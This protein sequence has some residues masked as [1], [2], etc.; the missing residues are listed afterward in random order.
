[1]NGSQI[2]GTETIKSNDLRTR[3]ER[4]FFKNYFT[5]NEINAAK[6]SPKPA[7]YLRKLAVETSRGGSGGDGIA[8]YSTRSGGKVEFFINPDSLTGEPTA[9]YDLKEL[10]KRLAATLNPTAT[11]EP[12]KLPAPNVLKKAAEAEEIFSDDKIFNLNLSNIVP[13]P[14]EP[15]SRRRSK[16]KPEDIED[17]ANSIVLQGLFSPIVV[18]PSRIFIEKQAARNYE[19]VF[20]ERRYLAHKIKNLDKIKCFVRELSDAQ[21]LEMQYQENHQRSDNDPL[22]DAFLFQYL[23]THEKYSDDDLADHFAKTKKEITEKLKLNDLIPEACAELSAGTLPLR[24]AYHL[25]KFPES[26]QREI[27]KSQLAYKYNDRSERAV[28]YHEFKAEV[29]ENIVRRLTDAPFSTIDPRLHIKQLICPKCPDR[30]GFETYLFPD[31]AKE[32]SCLNAACFRLKTNTH[33][34]LKREELAAKIPNPAM[35]SIE[36]QIKHVPLVTGKSYTDERAPFRE[37][38][39][40]NQKLMPEC[41]CE[42]SELSLIAEGIGKGESAYICR[43]KSCPVH[44]PPTEFDGDNLTDAE[45]GFDRQVAKHVRRKIMK[46]AMEWFDDRRTF[47]V[48]DNLIKNLIARFLFEI[49]G[50]YH[51]DISEAIR[52]WKNAPKNLKNPARIRSFVEGLDKRRQSQILFLLAHVGAEDVQLLKIAADYTDLKFHL[53]DAETRL[54]LSPEE[55]KPQARRYLQQLENG[56]AAEVPRIPGSETFDYDHVEMVTEDEQ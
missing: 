40:T 30:T 26:S 34:K 27:V 38:V 39:L 10:T 28:S 45:T 20:G 41:E 50:F 4:W 15:Q 13:S 22:D 6:K 8:F 33:L 23:K 2:D 53:L 9:I 48:F 49:D 52:D 24:H 51:A 54:E 12:K 21:V 16:F 19:I 11:A 7:E 1:M 37:K 25:A 43:E 35:N 56:Q 44:N 55:F 46:S 29:E 3:I 36:E 42:Y 14:F 17:L 47:W 32:D 18:R 5:R 31:L